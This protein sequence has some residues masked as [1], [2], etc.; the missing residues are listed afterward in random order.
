[1]SV[2]KRILIAIQQ[3]RLKRKKE[4]VEH[5]YAIINKLMMEMNNQFDEI[6]NSVEIFQTDIDEIKVDIDEV[7]MDIC[8]IST[9]S[10]NISFNVD[11]ITTSLMQLEQKK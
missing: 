1:M 10:E 4:K 3:H 11:V 8:S 9:F 5:L 2:I 6:R 7:K